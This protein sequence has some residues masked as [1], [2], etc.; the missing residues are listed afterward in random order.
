[1]ITRRF[2]QMGRYGEFDA[3]R[4]D[5]DRPATL[6]I[7]VG[8]LVLAAVLNMAMIV[9]GAVSLVGEGFQATTTAILFFTLSLGALFGVLLPL[10]VGIFAWRGS[11]GAALWVI[12]FLA[13]QIL[14]AFQS[15]NPLLY[16]IA[17]AAVLAVVLLWAPATR[18]YFR[19]MRESRAA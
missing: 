11:S 15:M 19:Q 8:A 18:A 12:L 6:R 2:G 16:L 4:R 10:V 17:S 3:P 5:A 13:E 7:G 14:V 1:V 9:S